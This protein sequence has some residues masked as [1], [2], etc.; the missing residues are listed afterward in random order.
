MI[1]KVSASLIVAIY[2]EIKYNIEI[3]FLGTEKDV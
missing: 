2:Q 1:E 3:A